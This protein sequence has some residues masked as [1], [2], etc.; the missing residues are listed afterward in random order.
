MIQHK[1]NPYPVVEALDDTELRANIQRTQ[2]IVVASL[3]DKQ[4]NLGGES[5]ERSLEISRTSPSLQTFDSGLC[6][7]G[8]IFGVKELVLDS[9]RILEDQQFLNLSM[10]AHKWLRIKQ[11]SARALK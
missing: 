5:V 2:L 8:E 7:T 4:A 6:R 11:V 10:T 9:I 1:A 3:I